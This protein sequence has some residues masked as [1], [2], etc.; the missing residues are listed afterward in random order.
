MTKELREKYKN[1]SY[2]KSEDIVEGTVTFRDEYRRY[3]RSISAPEIGGEHTKDDSLDDEQRR[4][5]R[6]RS[7]MAALQIAE[8]AKR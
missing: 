8:K 6:A 2:K 7:K 3:M 1:V 5:T 4:G